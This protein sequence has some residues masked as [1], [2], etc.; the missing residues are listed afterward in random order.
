MAVN[1]YYW[2]T[3]YQRNVAYWSMTTS[4]PIKSQIRR[5]INHTSTDL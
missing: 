5:Y 2:P 4:G 3:F 1:R